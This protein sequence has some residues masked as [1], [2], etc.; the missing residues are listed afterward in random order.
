MVNPQEA[1]YDIDP[2]IILNYRVDAFVSKEWSHT[3]LD[4]Y[5]IFSKLT[6]DEEGALV[7][8][9][10]LAAIDLYNEVLAFIEDHTM[11]SITEFTDGYFHYLDLEECAKYAQKDYQ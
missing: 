10:D 9:L 4:A 3:Y 5:S 6:L 11:Q 1:V 8:V 2:V 7:T